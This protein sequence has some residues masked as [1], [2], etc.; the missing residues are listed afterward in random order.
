MTTDQT[1]V[2]LADSAPQHDAPPRTSQR[3]W[4]VRHGET[5]W[6]ASGQHTSRTD[7]PLTER[8]RRRAAEIGRLLLGHSFSLVL[9]SPMLR[10]VDTCR[11]AGYGDAAQVEPNLREWDYGEYEGRTSAQILAER[12][13]W[14][15]WRDGTPGGENLLDVA[16]RAQTVID[17]ALLTS[18]DALL[19]G[20]GHILRVLACCWL[21]LPP[22]SGK[23]FALGTAGVTTLG[24]EHEN[25]VLLLLNGG[26][27]P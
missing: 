18:G 8:G 6:S 16:A 2:P 21:G 27:I 12:P 23:L 5:E 15:L 24:Y 19:F 13:G 26:L 3:L 9:S 1:Q 10:A 20:H 22:V 25:R 17:R 11:L 14:S 7:L 4:L